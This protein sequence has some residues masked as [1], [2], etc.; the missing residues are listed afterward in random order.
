[1]VYDLGLADSGI[2]FA[3]VTVASTYMLSTAYTTV[4]NRSQYRYETKTN[5][6]ISPSKK[7]KNATQITMP[8]IMCGHYKNWMLSC[9]RIRA[10][11]NLQATST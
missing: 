11:N 7:K 2:F 10:D 6:Q 5:T 3:L 4:A 1:M 9:T 8:T